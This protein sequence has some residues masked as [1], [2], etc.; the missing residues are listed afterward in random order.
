MVD[1]S[2]QNSQN[3]HWS[4]LGVWLV[5][6][7]GFVPCAWTTAA[8]YP[9]STT[10][11]LLT[12][13]QS[14]LFNDRFSAAYSSLDS[15]I[16]IHPDAPIGYLFKA[17]AYIA[18]M[19]DAEANLYPHRFRATADSAISLAQVRI[20]T[21]SP[22]ETAW[23]YL[24]IGHARAYESLW[25]S[26]FGSFS[27]ALSLGLKAKSSYEDGLAA[28]SSVYDL[29][30][31]LGMYHYW[32]SA[33]AGLLRMLRIFSNDKQK[34]I[35]ELYLTI[36]SSAISAATARNALIYIWLDCGQYDSV[37]TICDE[38]RKMYPEG[39]QFLW[40][41]AQAYFDSKQFDR[42]ADTYRTLREKL[43]ENPGNYFNL[44]E[45]DYDLYQCYDK[46]G[47]DTRASQVALGLNDYFDRIPQETLKRQRSKIGYLNRRAKALVQEAAN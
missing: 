21:T 35:D 24:I 14:D 40:P 33:K 46:R 6:V 25:E 9:D 15:F 36:D 16:R 8:T 31:G 42:A 23:M 34:G 41:L 2:L 27:S 26:R 37:V 44:V 1:R 3:S 45:C 22:E 10:R 30:G 32:K 11:A 29:Y 13:I 12:R 5:L 39:K 7:L 38:M 47:D 20:D 43:A 17:G 4:C 18:E 28:D 19:T